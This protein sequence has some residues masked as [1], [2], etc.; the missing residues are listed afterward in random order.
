MVDQISHITHIM[1]AWVLALQEPI[2]N[3]LRYK[4]QV[5]T[6]PAGVLATNSARPSAETVMT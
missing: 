5:I 4:N 1:T 6:V 2:L 3:I